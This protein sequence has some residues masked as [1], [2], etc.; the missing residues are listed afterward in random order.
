MFE[1]LMKP[2]TNVVEKEI[3]FSTGKVKLHFRLLT[4]SEWQV[5]R[6]GQVSSNYSDRANL[7]PWVITQSLCNTDGTQTDADGEP[8]MS[9]DE[10]KQL[11][12]EALILILSA[13]FE[14]NKGEVGKK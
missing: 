3:E 12:E 2:T 9:I 14:V 1:K 11:T 7:L 13:I 8:I 5:F 6:A 10:A 4:S